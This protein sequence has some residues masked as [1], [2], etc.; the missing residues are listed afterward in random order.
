MDDG[1]SPGMWI[2]FFVI[3]TGI[4]FAAVGFTA[5]MQN[6]S[7]PEA[8]KIEKEDEKHGKFLERYLERADRYL[9]VCRLMMLLAHMLLGFLMVPLG[10]RLIVH[11]KSGLLTV[12]IADV[13]VFAAMMLWILILG[14]YTPE[15]VAARKPGRWACLLISFIRASE[16]ILF[17]LIFMAD[18]LSDFLARLFG[19]D[20]H[21]DTDDVTEE[22][23][24][25][26]VNE[27]HEQGVLLA[28]EAEMIHNIFAFGDKEAKDIMT[29][30]KNITA[31]SASVTFSEAMDF[32]GENGHSRFPVYRDE[33]DNIIGVLHIKEALAL[34]TEQSV[35]QK[36]IGEIDGL[37]RD[38]DFIPE[39]RNINT[40]FAE[41][42][43]KKSHMV[44]V[45]DEY[46][47]T[48]GVVAMEDILEEIVGNIEDEHDDE[49][50]MIVMASDGSYL[51]DGLASFSEV[52]E[53]LGIIRE[54][55]EED[56][57]ETINGFLISQLGRIPGDGEVFSLQAGG[58]LFEVRSV[59]NKMI[60][61]VRAE[62]LPE[63]EGQQAAARETD[64]AA[65]DKAGDEVRTGGKQISEES[66][67]DSCKNPETVIE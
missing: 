7:G 21:S 12:L 52:A 50:A 64:A 39:T 19:V 57:F 48:A 13:L 40:L 29:H 58:C 59:E 27:G 44:I 6:L 2:L 66:G 63:R 31:L 33:I 36:A 49:D 67:E 8:E 55:E 45:V 34:C 15:K 23:I 62:K 1:V 10:R 16:I 32:L 37:I 46:G 61:S 14:I 35:Y 43:A 4:D 41:M 47:Q 3:L 25:S 54:D 18:F 22:E 28:S 51:I 65:V 42:Q 56:T 60:R 53:T 17:P 24:I 9:Q 5:A 26:M 30:R 11:G 20:P 38:V